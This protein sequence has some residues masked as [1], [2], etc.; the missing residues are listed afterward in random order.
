[1][2]KIIL[3]IFNQVDELKS[4]K[5]LDGTAVIYERSNICAKQTMQGAFL[6][7]R[8]DRMKTMLAVSIDDCKNTLKNCAIS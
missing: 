5:R 1:M 6:A 8:R 3:A 4:I 7:V 2:R